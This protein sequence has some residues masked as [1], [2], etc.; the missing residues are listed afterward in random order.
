VE[1]RL[2]GVSRI[3][4]R[5][6]GLHVRV[7]RDPQTARRHL[8]TASKNPSV[9]AKTTSRNTAATSWCDQEELTAMISAPTLSPPVN[10][11]VRA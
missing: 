2:H 3:V 8:S 9:S 11:A 6:P 4:G 1:N 5:Q 7:P 10:P